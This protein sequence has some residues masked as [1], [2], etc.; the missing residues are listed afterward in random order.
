M[1]ETPEFKAFARCCGVEGEK[2]CTTLFD[3]RDGTEKTYEEAKRECED[4][5]LR[6]C[7]KEEL[8]A[9]VCR[10]TGGQCDN[11]R[12]WTS[13]ETCGDT[14]DRLGRLN[15]VAAGATTTTIM[16]PAIGTST[17]PAQDDMITEGNGAPTSMGDDTTSARAKPTDECECLW[18]APE[19]L[20]RVFWYILTVG[21]SSGVA[22]IF[23]KRRPRRTR[24]VYVKDQPGISESVPEAIGGMGGSKNIGNRQDFTL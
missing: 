7:T 19:I 24:I 11:F 12:I 23:A 6:L 1:G 17:T 20:S 9:S 15:S 2:P 18:T 4:E 14:G 22:F 13:A 16:A 8:E 5:D 3:C 21:T 10:G